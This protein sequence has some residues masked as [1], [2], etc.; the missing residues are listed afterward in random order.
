[1]LLKTNYTVSGSA[2]QAAIAQSSTGEFKFT[3]NSPVDDFFYDP[4]LIKPELVGT[5]WEEILKTLPSHQGE[6][7]I[8]TLAPGTAYRSHADADDRWHLN[9]IAENAFICNLDTAEM[10]KLVTDGIWYSMNAGPR[11]TATN[12]GHINRV[13]LVVRQLLIKV[14]LNQ[15]VNVRICLRKETTN[16]RYQFDNTVSPWLNYAQKSN[17]ISDFKFINQEVSFAIEQS[18]LPNLKNILPDMFEVIQ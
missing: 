11:H 13:Q 2:L 17:L 1:M 10:Y 4:W 18:M 16:F 12:F 8:I 15:P 6:A 5:V 9:L 14:I 7:R 3:L